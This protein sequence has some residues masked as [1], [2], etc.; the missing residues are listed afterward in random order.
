MKETIWKYI[1]KVDNEQ[2][3]DMPFG[4]QFLSVQVQHGEPCLWVRCQSNAQEVPVKVVTVSTGN[5]AEHVEGMQF[6]GTYQLD[7]G[8]FVRH[9]FVQV[10]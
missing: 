7:N 6:V 2:V 4:A 1:L 3:I 10:G 9:V 5:P 8:G